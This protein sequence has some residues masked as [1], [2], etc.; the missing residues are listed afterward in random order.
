MLN[1]GVRDGGIVDTVSL[2]ALCKVL[3]RV[4]ILHKFGRHHNHKAG[5]YLPHGGKVF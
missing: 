2:V 3:I 1:S 5:D 4:A